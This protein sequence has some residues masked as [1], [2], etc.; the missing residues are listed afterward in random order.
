MKSPTIGSKISALDVNWSN[1]KKNVL[2][3]L[4]DG[5]R[6]CT[7]SADFYKTLVQ[8]T[9]DKNVSVTAVLPQDKEV[10][11]KYL[12]KLQLPEIESKQ[13]ALNTLDVS[14]TPT[15]IIADAQGQ[16]EKVWVGKLPS[17]KQSEVLALLLQ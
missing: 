14:A 2:L 8:Q 11:R 15:L 5:C 17:E 10:A 13:S 3:V 4:Q 9:K 1:N 6:Y 7:E 16:V 12:D